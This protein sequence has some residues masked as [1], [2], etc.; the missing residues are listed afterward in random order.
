M[1]LSCL[2]NLINF[3]AAI[4][5]NHSVRTPAGF[6]VSSWSFSQ[7]GA[8]PAS[9]FQ[10]KGQD[11]LRSLHRNFAKMLARDREDSPG[12]WQRLLLSHQH[13]ALFLVFSLRQ[14]AKLVLCQVP[15]RQALCNEILTSHPTPSPGRGHPLYSLHRTLGVGSGVTSSE[16]EGPRMVLTPVAFSWHWAHPGGTLGGVQPLHPGPPFLRASRF[17]PEWKVSSG[18]LMLSHSSLEEIQV[19]CKAPTLRDTFP[20]TDA[21]IPCGSRAPSRAPTTLRLASQ[22]ELRLEKRGPGA[23]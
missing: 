1:Y 9:G 22:S 3:Q 7:A 8:I 18:D 21:N 16:G 17:P 4:L 14:F 19:R 5:N 15:A 13:P 6:S 11:I 10:V 12:S 20:P 23:E 2:L